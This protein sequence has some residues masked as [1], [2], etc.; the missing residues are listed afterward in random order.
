MTWRMY[1]VQTYERSLRMKYLQRKSEDTLNKDMK[2]NTVN[3]KGSEE[4]RENEKDIN[5]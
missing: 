5:K 4:S 2:T 1:I 3:T